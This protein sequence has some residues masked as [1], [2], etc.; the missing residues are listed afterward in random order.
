MK[1]P[2][3]F[4][5][6]AVRAAS[7][8]VRAGSNPLIVLPTGSGKSLVIAMLNK[9]AMQMG[10]RVLNLTH[11][12]TL[13]TQDASEFLD[14]TDHDAPF[15]I[16]CAGMGMRQFDDD[17]VFASVQTYANVSKSAPSFD[18]IIIDEAHRIPPK[19]EGQY[20]KVIT[21]ETEKNKNIRVIGVTATPYRMGQGVLTEGEGVVF[22]EIAYQADYLRLVEE[23]FL[24]PV[25]S[26]KAEYSTNLDGVHWKT[27]LKADQ[28]CE[29]RFMQLLPHQ[30][31]SFIEISKERGKLLIFGQTIKHATAIS[32][33]M[34]AH[35]VSC[36]CVHSE[37]D[38]E[39]SD[40]IK[41]FK[42]GEFRA[43]ASV[44]M[45]TTGVNVPEVDCIGLFFGT[46][47]TSK[48]VQ[49]VGRGTRTFPGKE[50]CLVADY[51]GNIERHGPIDMASQRPPGDSV[52]PA[53]SCPE[54]DALINMSS[55][56]C[57]HCG[58]S[59]GATS[60]KR[61]G[62]LLTEKNSTLSIISTEPSRVYVESIR[63]DIVE[64]NWGT[65]LVVNFYNGGR[66]P[67]AN[68]W[69][70]FWHYKNSAKGYA[71]KKLDM[72]MGYEGAHLDYIDDDG[73]DFAPIL[74]DTLEKDLR[75]DEISWVDVIPSKSNPK[76][77]DIIAV[78]RK[79]FER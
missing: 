53:K 65:G 44:Q 49:V 79:G 30:C 12:H 71:K 41:K 7:E 75:R 38:I 63:V 11:D 42:N 58:F 70:L 68:L 33:F 62:K 32:D 26:P 16:C 77:K 24:A 13:I 23:G 6:D 25:I 8:S 69:L 76:F 59:F 72:L 1:T 20:L 47:S 34:N 4:Q 39:K 73:V 29:E 21:Q 67:A 57:P 28:E 3:Y 54:C 60:V 74:A 18:Y 9:S 56:L 5:L 35:G 52:S 15:G 27:P 45:L 22:D 19:G 66:W 17:I 36:C 55:Q 48:Y 37:S 10:K 61:D 51:G 14:F 78:G 64:K 46:A 50:N 40:A 2:Y 31:S 43:L